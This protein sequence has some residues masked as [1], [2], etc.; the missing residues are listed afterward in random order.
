MALFALSENFNGFFGKINPGASFVA[1]AS[2]EHTTVTGLIEDRS[3]LA[4]ELSPSCFLQGSYRQDTAINTINDVDIVVLCRLWYPSS[5]GGGARTYSRDDIFRIIAAPLLNDGRYSSKVRFGANSMC[6]KV[7][8]GIKLEILPVVF[9]A[10]TYDPS[11]EPFALY[12]PSSQTWEDGYARL[13]QRWLTHKN[14][15]SGNFIP[16]IK[17]LKHLRSRARLD[18]VSFHLE[19]LLCSLPDAVFKNGPAEYIPAFLRAIANVSATGWYMKRVLTPCGERDIFSTQ[20]WRMESW[21]RFH[22]GVVEWSRLADIAA[23]TP[24]RNRAIA[25][26]K[27]LFGD[28]FFPR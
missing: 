16:S 25:A 18:A 1:Q 13:H 15:N 17:V 10:G 2:R 20:E 23:A 9:K 19:C 4:A 7:D 26:W 14:Q 21:G 8:L 24:D 11:L 3:G 27:T 22:A 28:D 6:I 12:R 5:G